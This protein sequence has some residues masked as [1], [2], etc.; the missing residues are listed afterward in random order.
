MIEVKVKE[1]MEHL[2]EL[3]AMCMPLLLRSKLLEVSEGK[4]IDR[5][6][7]DNVEEAKTR[8]KNQ[9]VER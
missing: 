4:L 5:Y 1:C 8:L 7:L 2:R 3:W 6:G 9:G